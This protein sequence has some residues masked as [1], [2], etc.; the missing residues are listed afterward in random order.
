MK[1]F[2][3]DIFTSNQGQ[4]S[5]KRVAGLFMISSGTSAK[6]ALIAYGSK[7]KIVEK[8][9]LYD[10]LDMTADSLIWAGAALIGLG[11]T[12]LFK[13]KDDK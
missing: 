6:L 1:A 13:K 2:I 4:I 5:S 8:F 3:K 10:K 7:I 11:V 12:E 9:S